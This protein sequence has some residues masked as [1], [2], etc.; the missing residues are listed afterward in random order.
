MVEGSLAVTLPMHRCDPKVG[1]SLAV[2]L[3]MDRWAPKVGGSIAVTYRWTDG[4]RRLE[5]PSLLLTDG[6]MGSQGWS[7][8]RLLYRWTD[9]NLG[10]SNSRW[11]VLYIYIF[12]FYS[13]KLVT[14]LTNI[15]S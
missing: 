9:G 5:G 12:K 13:G 4:L 11:D 2:V 15:M 14:N 10:V 8:H 7:V 6:P 3:P 1:G